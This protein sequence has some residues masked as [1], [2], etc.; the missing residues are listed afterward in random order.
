M[1]ESPNENEFY[2]FKGFHCGYS[3]NNET[4]WDCDRHNDDT[5]TGHVNKNGFPLTL[6]K[7]PMETILKEDFVRTGQR[8]KI[9]RNLPQVF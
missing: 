2:T 1:T 3:W 6:S 4:I 9:P 5:F 7:G 8:W